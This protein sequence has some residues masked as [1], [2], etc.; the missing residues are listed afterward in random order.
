MP[1]SDTV[2]IHL[3]NRPYT[4]EALHNGI[5]NFSALARVIQAELR[6]K[7]HHAVKAALIRYAEELMKNRIENERRAL[8][9]LS[10]NRITL[11]DGMFVT[12]STKRFEIEN[13]AEIKLG[14]YYVYLTKRSVIKSLPQRD[15]KELVKTH[16]DCSVIVISS[17]PHLENVPGV[18]ALLTAI[19]AEQ[20]INV[21][22]LISC[23]TETILVINREDALKTYEIFFSIVKS[24]ANL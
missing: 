24:N 11:L 8:S 14:R 15:K 7:S 17:E 12:I 3:K 9:V 20:N 5:V 19:L 18:I 2:R 13:E 23:Y 1:I 10:E 16:S 4:L 6:I 21:I 22:E